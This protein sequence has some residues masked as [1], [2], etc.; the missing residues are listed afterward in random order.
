[1]GRRS[2]RGHF[3]VSSVS[4][5]Y[6]KAVLLEIPSLA[7]CIA[8]SYFWIRYLNTGI[9]RLLYVFALFL[10]KHQA[11]YLPVFC[12]LTAVARQKWALLFNRT[13]VWALGIIVIL[14]APYYLLAFKVHGPALMIVARVSLAQNAP[15]AG[16]RHVDPYN[17]YWRKL[18]EQLG[19]PLL[20]LSVA[21]VAT[22][23]WW[24]KKEN[25]LVMLL[26]IAACYLGLS[27]RGAVEP[28]YMIYWL[29]SFV[30]FAAVP[31][32]AMFSRKWAALPGATAAMALFGTYFVWSWTYERP[33][34]SGYAVV[35]SRLTQTN[36]SGFV[37]FDGELP[38]NFIFLCAVLILSVAFLSYARLS[39]CQA[40]RRLMPRL[41]TRPRN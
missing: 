6:E 2:I 39:I 8:A 21:G 33:Y 9:R 40:G 18:P 36:D 31:L 3:G 22:C 1:M 25:T 28:R 19:W 4:F 32:T 16:G 10:T 30:Y 20:L 23:K 37:L 7:L 5:P 27:F 17:Y 38:G 13:A 11:V 12:L 34:L 24:D 41:F 29:P 35:A 15:M 14:T 26:W